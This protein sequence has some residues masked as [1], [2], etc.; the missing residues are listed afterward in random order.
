MRAAGPDLGGETFPWAE[1][2]WG[3][4]IYKFEVVQKML[5]LGPRKGYTN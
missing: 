3:Q 5:V 2:L 4:G 1:K